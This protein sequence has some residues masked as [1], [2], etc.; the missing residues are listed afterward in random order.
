AFPSPAAPTRWKGRRMPS[1]A[2]LITDSS[3]CIPRPLLRRHD[4]RVVAIQVVV[5]GE[6]FRD[7]V[8][9]NRR[10]LY[11][12]LERGVAVK[13]SAPSPLDYLD[14]IEAVPE[15]VTPVIVTP[16]AEF[17]RMPQNAGLAAA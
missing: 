10:K 14:A 9:L 7:G 13:S 5:G 12:A 1:A 2:V 6:E 3:A 17:T 15:D 4:I 11:G 8:N 16:A